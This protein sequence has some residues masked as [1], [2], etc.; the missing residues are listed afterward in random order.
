MK[1]L[2]IYF[3]GKLISNISAD[4]ARSQNL[5]QS[6]IDAAVDESNAAQAKHQKRQKVARNVGDILSLHGTTSDATQYIIK[7]HFELLTAL[8]T[9]KT[10]EDV[11]AATLPHL[12]QAQDFLAKIESR[13]VVLTSD[14][15][16]EE[17]VL[18]E[19]AVRATGVSNI[20]V[21]N[22]STDAT[23]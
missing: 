21:P 17:V 7:A 4:E 13:E 8:A 18:E 20:V 19:I 9:V 15:K 12:T 16:G 2:T 11:R 22:Y 10:L 14:A 5:P 1:E 23:G 6:V 3:G